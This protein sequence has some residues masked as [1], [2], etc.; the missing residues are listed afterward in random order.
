MSVGRIRY[1]WQEAEIEAIYNTP[2]LELIYQAASVH[3]QY[4]NPKQIQVCK[5]ISIKTG[6]CPEDCNYCA[7]SSRYKTEVKAQALLEKETVV[8]IAQKA[9]ETGVSRV[10]MGA[11]WR[12]VKDNSQFETV[13]EMVQD[14]TSMGL[15]VCCTLGMLTADQA[16]RLEDAGLYAYNHN[17]DTS[18]E[19]Y[20]TIITTRTYDDRLNTI[21]NVRQTNVTVCSGGILGLG[22]TASDRIA[23]LHTLANLSPHPESVPINI[24][25][26]V[27]G[28]PLENQ[29]DVPIWEIVRMIATARIIMPASDVRLSAGRARLSEVEQ[30]FCFMAGANSIFS[31][32]D[33]KM[34]TVTTPCP[35]YDSDREMLN[36]LGL[37]MRPPATREVKVS[38]PATVG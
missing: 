3:R 8:S 10:C 19:H 23:M 36:L 15:E 11:A 6:G 4:H 20:S 7:Q 1:D 25:S 29:P 35:D 17:L 12:E 2:L 28:T 14:V 38:T 34:L 31:S 24:L 32:D 27:P 9:K 21:E 22:E 5:L 18:R 30:A 26:Q 13:L 16:K 33:N 37:E